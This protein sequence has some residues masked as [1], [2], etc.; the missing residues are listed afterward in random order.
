M[1][2]FTVLLA[3]LA[4]ML[5]VIEPATSGELSDGLAAYRRG[6]Y[7]TAAAKLMRLAVR[8][9]SEAQTALG[10]M[11]EYGRGVPQDE[12]IAAQWYMCAADQGNADALYQLGLM[13]DKGHGV[14]RSAV[15]A[16]Q[17]LNLAAA[18]ARPSER[19]DYLRIRDAVATKLNRAQIAEAQDRARVFVPIRTLCR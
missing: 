10:F 3:V 8:G 17:L 5:V 11:Y 6:N 16:Y 2:K 18:R 19:D 1:G 15:Q 4:L 7:A 12:V 14:P 13:Y 9:N